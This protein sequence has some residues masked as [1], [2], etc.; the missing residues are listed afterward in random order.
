MS[1]ANTS[2][3]A[4]ERLYFQTETSYGTAPGT[5]TGANHALHTSVTVGTK[6]ETIKSTDKTGTDSATPGTPGV[7]SATETLTWE[8]RT[9]SAAGSLPDANVLYKA[10]I[11]SDP[12]VV[13]G[14]SV[15]Y[16][17]GSNPNSFTWFRFI[18][19]STAIQQMILGTVVS[20]FVF[21]FASKVNCT[22][23]ATLKS[24]WVDNSWNH[25]TN[26]AIARGG[27][28]VGAFPSEPSTPVTNG[29]PINALQGLFSI[30]SGTAQRVTGTLEIKGNP[31]WDSPTNQLA[32]G[33]YGSCPARVEAQ[34]FVAGLQLVFEDG[35][36]AR[37]LV[38]KA[39]SITS[40]GA[41]VPCFFQAGI[42][43]GSKL[44][45]TLPNVKLEVPTL[46][47][48]PGDGKFYLD[49]PDMQAFPSTFGANDE[50]TLE[51]S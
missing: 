34:F 21:T 33:Q 28:A 46:T 12:V 16:T 42:T 51:F 39:E 2:L 1:C 9:P 4:K 41:Y 35:S 13:A 3:T 36:I 11:G 5:L 38:A 17:K 8:A 7:R 47:E 22:F 45:W 14:T 31:G 40:T 27:I 25:D 32:A 37:N 20:D 50:V 19:P 43:A 15:K 18:Q 30:D 24:L 23:K 29:T 49:F 6:Q 48:G 26:D 10:M 44:R